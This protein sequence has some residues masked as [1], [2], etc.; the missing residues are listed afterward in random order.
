MMGRQRDDQAQFFYALHLEERVPAGHLLS[1]IDVFV[2]PALDD[3]HR[4]ITA[5]YSHTGRPNS[6]QIQHVNGGN[7]EDC[8]RHSRP[9]DCHQP[10]G[11]G[12]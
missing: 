5:F 4:E 11:F 7:H 3:I 1:R 12:C 9:L 6:N 10:A 2:T 8:F